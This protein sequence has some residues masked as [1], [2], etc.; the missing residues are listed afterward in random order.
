[1]PPGL[2]LRVRRHVAARRL[3]AEPG[4]AVLAVSGGADSLALLD[5]FAALGPTLGLDL[6]VGKV[7]VIDFPNRRFHLTAAPSGSLPHGGAKRLS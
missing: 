7:L 2:P 1:M 5:L 3:F 4:L 6:L